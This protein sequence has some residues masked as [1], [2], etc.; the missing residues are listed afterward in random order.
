MANPDVTA[1]V[2]DAA[3]TARA[4]EVTAASFT[5]GM[6]NAASNAPGIGVNVA[7]GAVTGDNQQFTLL[8]QDGAARDPQVSQLI[9]GAGFV[10]RSSV[11]YDSSGGVAGK[12]TLPL[13]GGPQSATYPDGTGAITFTANVDLLVLATGWAYQP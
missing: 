9:G 12:S 3:V 7:G 2:E 13:R 11:A 10:D 1:F 5:T 8:D 4:L 6:N